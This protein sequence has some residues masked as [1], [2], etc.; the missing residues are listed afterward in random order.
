MIE[1][2]GLNPKQMALADI[3]WAISSQEGVDAFIATLPTAEQRECQTLIE[4]MQL[5]FM[6]EVSDTHDASMVIDRIAKR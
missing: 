5:A 6:D 2:Q 1:I 3:M 4:L